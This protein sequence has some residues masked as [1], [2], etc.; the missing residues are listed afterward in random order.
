MGE[1]RLRKK[2][3][4]ALKSFYKKHNKKHAENKDKLEKLV[5]K[6]GVNAGKF[7]KLTYKLV[8]KYY[9]KSIKVEKDPQQAMYE[10]MMN[11]VKNGRTS[12]DFVDGTNDGTTKNAPEDGSSETETVTST[13]YVE[14]NGESEVIDLDE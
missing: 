7:A 13:A 12:D 4:K 5:E 14:D 8:S 1:G 10:A 3:V 9:P 2:R 6:H 11:D